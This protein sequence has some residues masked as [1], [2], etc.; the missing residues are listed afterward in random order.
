MKSIVMIVVPVVLTV[1]IL[2]G[3]WQL[4]LLPFG[5]SAAAAGPAAAPTRPG[6]VN[7]VL[8]ERVVNL[9]DTPG[10]RYLKI[11]ITLAFAD[12]KHRP[13]ELQ[14][15]ALAAEEAAFKTE[16]DPDDPAMEDFEITTLTGKTAAELLT[17]G[18]KDRL[19]AEL[20]DGL[21]KQV[22]TPTLEAVYFTEFVIQ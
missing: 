11:Q 13:G 15:D 8:P 14:G 6:L 16:I 19:R 7:Y 3:A 9:A 5:T 18:G 10:Y 1:G 22:P 2:A 12:P 4:K 20:L 17:P 21:R